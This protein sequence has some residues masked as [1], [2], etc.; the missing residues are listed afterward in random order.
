[1]LCGHWFPDSKSPFQGQLLSLVNIRKGQKN[2]EAIQ[3]L[4][5]FRRHTIK[6]KKTPA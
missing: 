4:K 6:R 3:H 1:M 5:N 2:V